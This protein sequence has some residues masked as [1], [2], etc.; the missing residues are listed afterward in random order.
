MK[1]QAIAFDLDDTLLRGNRTV[2]DFTITVLRKAA[3]RGIHIIPASGRARDSM[4]PFVEQIGCASL[5]VSCNGA[6]IWT[7]EHKEVAREMLDVELAREVARY[8]VARDCYAQTY[9]GR[10]F[11]YSRRGRWAEAYAESS[12]LEGVYVGDLEAFLTQPTPKILMMD[13]EQKIADML[14]EAGSLFAGRLSICCSKP[15]FLEFNPLRATKGI[16]LARCAELL[17][18]EMANTVAFGDSLNDLSMLESAGTGVAMAN[19]REDVKA[20]ITRHCLSN[21]EDGVA[22]YIDEYILSG[23]GAESA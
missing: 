15:Y 14:K 9:A 13:E 4:K 16:A 22:R 2:S 17:G 12:M 8:G 6:E 5:Y 23:E 21:G 3:A 7:P 20:R 18:F 19:A 10:Y 11:Y 1:T